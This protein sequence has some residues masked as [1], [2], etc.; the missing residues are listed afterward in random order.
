MTG[1]RPAAKISI[2][3]VQKGCS[4]E[5]CWVGRSDRAD[6]GGASSDRLRHSHRFASHRLELDWLNRCRSLLTGTFAYGPAYGA[7]GVSTG[8]VKQSR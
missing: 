4:H 2:V 8:S 3:Q 5:Q 6:L 1:G 7:F